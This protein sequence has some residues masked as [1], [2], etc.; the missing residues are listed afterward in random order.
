MRAEIE[1]LS[2]HQQLSER[3]IAALAQ[4]ENT[5][6]IIKSFQQGRPLEKVVGD[7]DINTTSQDLIPPPQPQHFY[8]QFDA[9]NAIF[10]SVEAEKVMGYLPRT[11]FAS[12]MLLPNQPQ[13]FG[14]LSIDL[15]KSSTG[16]SNPSSA[17]ASHAGGEN[18]MKLTPEAAN[19]AASVICPLVGNW[20]ADMADHSIQIDRGQS[21]ILGPSFGNEEHFAQR[22]MTE[23]G[24]TSVTKNMSLIEHLLTLYFCWE[25]PTFASLSKEHFLMDFRT[26]RWRYCSPLLV[27]ALLALGS[28]FSTHPEARKNSQDSMTAGDHF[29]D[30]A[31]RL[32]EQQS[33]PSLMMVQAFGLMSIR[34]AS[35]GRNTDSWYYSGQSIR[36][37]VELGLHKE[38]EDNDEST[39]MDNAVRAATFW[40]AF[41]L[42]Q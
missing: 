12:N 19:A 39:L 2:R 28:R 36:M 38:R 42:D 40:G 9:R 14:G 7:L 35:C 32:L 31:K 13:L 10:N 33:E 23:F 24:W 17:S 4:G 41:A 20:H 8:Q 16:T 34:E 11:E 15:A 25:Y 5:D 21:Y 26:N 29:F 37:A 18:S 1:Q 27:N 6:H 22:P 30:E 3:L